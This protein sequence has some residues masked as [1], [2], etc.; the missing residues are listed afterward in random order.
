MTWKNGKKKESPMAWKN[1]K[2]WVCSITYDAGRQRLLVH[3]LP[4]TI[5]RR[6]SAGK[7]PK[8]LRERMVALARSTDKVLLS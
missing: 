1:W 7:M 4:L 3:A 6:E 5:E 2:K 8:D